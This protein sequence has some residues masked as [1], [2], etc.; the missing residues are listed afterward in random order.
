MDKEE[1]FILEMKAER[2]S[3]QMALFAQV[4]REQYEFLKKLALGIDWDQQNASCYYIGEDAAETILMRL[5]FD[6]NEGIC[7]E[8]VEKF[9]GNR[10]GKEEK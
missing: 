2:E 10:E 6:F 1:K 4:K 9:V 8:A 5:N 3:F 7:N